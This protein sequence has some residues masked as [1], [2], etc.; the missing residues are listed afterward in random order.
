MISTTQER[1]LKQLYHDPSLASSLGGVDALY[2]HVRSQ[3]RHKLSRRQIRQWLRSQEAYTLH[4][5]VRYRYSRNRTLV[6]G[7]DDQWQAD[8]VD[9]SSL[10][11]YNDG[12]RYLLVVIDILSKFAWIRKLKTKT[13][14]EVTAAFKS[15]LS[16]GRQPR[17]L[18]CDQGREF[19]NSSF[20]DLMRTM[21]IKL[22]ATDSDTKA[23]IV[24][25][26]NR[27]LK[28]RMWRF[29]TSTNTK[30][31]VDALQRLVEGYNNRYHRSIG[32]APSD[33]T[34][35]KEAVVLERLYK[36]SSAAPS[37]REFSLEVGD[38]VRIS[39]AR[40]TFRKGYLQGWSTEIFTVRSRE[41]RDQPSYKLE[42]YAGESLSGVFYEEEL[43]KVSAPAAYKVEKVLRKRKTRDG[44]EEYFVKWL[45]YP[46]KFNSWVSTVETV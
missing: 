45:G 44:Q 18:Q 27:T 31:Y 26:F 28:Q 30:R 21:G 22:F 33:V 12:Y 24:E 23:A 10:S 7:I 42:D 36:P 29:F 4:H 2:R 15:I 41:H 6:S 34:Q 43:Q 20:Q 5:P 13:G 38:L 1:Y 25:R 8:L 19:F 35:D 9:L 16:D 40:M 14:I 37:R 11:K 3:G 32:M 17:K 39:Q 46:E